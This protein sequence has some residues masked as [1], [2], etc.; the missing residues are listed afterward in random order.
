MQRNETTPHAR[1]PLGGRT[2]RF[3]QAG[4]AVAALAALVLATPGAFAQA[5]PLPVEE[6]DAQ[7]TVGTYNIKAKVPPLR[8]VHDLRRLD[9]AGVD[10]IGLQEMRSAPR[11]LAIQRSLTCAECPFDAYLLDNSGPA[12]ACP[13]LWRKAEFRLLGGGAK[14]VT[15]RTYVGPRGAGGPRLQAKYVVWVKLEHLGTD[16]VVYVLNNHAVPTVDVKHPS[17]RRL[18]LHRRHMEVLQTLVRDKARTGA[19]VFAVGDFNVNFRGDIIHRSRFFPYAMMAKVGAHSN[20]QQLGAP[21]GGTHGTRLIDYVFSRP[22]N[23]TTAVHQ[24]MLG[25]YHSDHKPVL[26]TYRVAAQVEPPEAAGV[27]PEGTRSG[28]LRHLRSQPRLPEPV[29]PA[30]TSG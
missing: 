22:A 15:G 21:P 1:R 2:R 6:P 27:A 8:V 13:I 4:Y 3:G 5:Q 19:A 17:P 20:W 7:L 11:K 16:K 10:V 26:V 28:T 30:L 29:D 18:R 24:A 25:G 14:L 9:T 23:G 12:T